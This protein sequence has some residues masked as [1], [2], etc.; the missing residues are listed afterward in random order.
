MKSW[1]LSNEEKRKKNIT[2]DG[3]HLVGLFFFV[4]RDFTPVA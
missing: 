3:W 2:S 4:N 1:G